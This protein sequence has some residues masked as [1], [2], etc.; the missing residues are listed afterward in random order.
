MD[1]SK[2]ALADII[3]TG[4]Y[5][6][7]AVFSIVCERICAFYWPVDREIGRFFYDLSSAFWPFLILVL[8]FL[9]VPTHIILSVIGIAKSKKVLP[10]ILTTIIPIILF[11]AVFV[12]LA[13]YA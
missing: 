1:K 9:L 13:R 6:L 11:I 5:S 10:Y 4:L 7:L 3:V 2:I 12:T 8:P